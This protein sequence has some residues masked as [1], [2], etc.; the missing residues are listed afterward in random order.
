MV[1]HRVHCVRKRVEP[2]QIAPAIWHR[3]TG[4]KRAQSID[5]TSILSIYSFG[6]CSNEQNKINNSIRVEFSRNS[7]RWSDLMRSCL[8]Q[9][10]YD[11]IPKCS[12]NVCNTFRLKSKRTLG[13]FAQKIFSRAITSNSSRLLKIVDESFYFDINLHFLADGI[14][15]A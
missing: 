14:H 12:H 3:Y 9:K 6:L 11:K 10:K 7:S 8:V 5:A 15:A 4:Q 2:K 13:N 1:V